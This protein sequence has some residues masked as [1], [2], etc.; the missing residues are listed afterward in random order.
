MKSS[1][2]TCE[3][4]RKR[5]DAM[6]TAGRAFARRLSTDMS[7]AM[8]NPTS[9]TPIAARAR[10]WLRSGFLS[11]WAYLIISASTSRRDFSNAISAKTGSGTDGSGK[12]C[13]RRTKP[14]TASSRSAK[15]LSMTWHP[16]LAKPIAGRPFRISLIRISG[17]PVPL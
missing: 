2:H 3:L 7:V 12:R 1:V 13:D 16:S 5:F 6:S 4:C 10:G 9:C 11:V 15:S 8:A 17:A 14:P